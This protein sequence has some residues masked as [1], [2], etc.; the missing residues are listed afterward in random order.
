MEPESLIQKYE[1][2]VARLVALKATLGVEEGRL[3]FLPLVGLFVGIAV[4]ALTKPAYGLLPLALS[5]VTVGTGLYLTRVHRM[6]RDYN[7]ARAKKE[8]AR[9]KAEAKAI[10]GATGTRAS[11]PSPSLS[12]SSTSPEAHAGAE[13]ASVDA[14]GSEG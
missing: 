12:P 6:E 4:G 10:G 7:L 13:V 8:L 14:K 9:L 3:K 1:A 5:V 2:E 11:A